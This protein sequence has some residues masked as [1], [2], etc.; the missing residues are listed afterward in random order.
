MRLSRREQ[1]AVIA[2]GTVLAL[3][4]LLQF[5]VLPLADRRTRLEKGLAARERAVAE[6]IKV[7]TATRTKTIPIY[8]KVQ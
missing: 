5:V 3:F 6:T 4:V 8:V 7:P 2:A 1:W